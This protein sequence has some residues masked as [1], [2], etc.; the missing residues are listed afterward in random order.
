MVE[1]PKGHLIHNRYVVQSR[2]GGGGH[3]DVYEVLDLHLQRVAAL[4]L[5]P[6]LSGTNHWAEAEVLTRLQS[7]Y[8]LEV[9]NADV[10]AGV[11]FIV[12]PVARHGSADLHMN[13]H[14]VPPNQA[15]RW[16]R[17]TSRGADRAH[18]ERLVHRDIKPANIF[19][20][21][22]GEALLGDFGIAHLMDSHGLAPPH[23]TPITKAPEVI[24]NNPCS[25]ASDIYSLGATLYALLAGRYPYNNP[26]EALSGPPPELRDLAPHVSRALNKRVR[27][28]MATDP[29][30]RYSSAADFASALGELPEYRRDWQ[31]TDEHQEHDCCWRGDGAGL[32]P[33]TVCMIQVGKRF[34]VVAAHQPS[35]RKI[36]KGCRAA[37][38]PSQ[39]SRNLRAAISAVS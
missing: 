11:P 5:L 20:T 6:S 37:A 36:G 7:D 31:R 30:A 28:A 10:D 4:K 34:E 26:A 32:T 24:L 38:P 33:V 22:E 2:L 39:I 18:Q 1:L 9:W 8:I 16:V 21:K 27:Q 19:L 29:A 25:V 15:I 14:G 13:P 23:G 17:D 3:G 12:T 35:E